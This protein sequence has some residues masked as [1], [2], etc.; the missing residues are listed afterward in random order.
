[1]DDAIV[2]PF[3]DTPIDVHPYHVD[4][5]LPTFITFQIVLLIHITNKEV[6]SL[7]VLSQWFFLT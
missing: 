1:M 2:G 3:L 4:A 5:F 7:L 6:R